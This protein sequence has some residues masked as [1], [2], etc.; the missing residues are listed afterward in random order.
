MS[1]TTSPY[2]ISPSHT[3]PMHPEEQLYPL[4]FKST[5]L[6]YDSVSVNYIHLNCTVGWALTNLYTCV[7]TTKIK[8]HNSLNFSLGKIISAV[9]EDLDLPSVGGKEFS[10]Q[11][12]NVGKRKGSEECSLLE[13]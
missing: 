7:A 13:L 10:I 11:I 6:R 1:T 8:I 3:H 4:L 2:N 9:S 5:L 12:N